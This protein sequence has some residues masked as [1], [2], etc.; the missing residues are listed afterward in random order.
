MFLS[1]GPYDT[2][3]TQQASEIIEYGTAD[4]TRESTPAS[5]FLR[6]VSSLVRS[7][8]RVTGRTLERRQLM[9]VQT[10]VCLRLLVALPSPLTML[11]TKGLYTTVEFME[12]KPRTHN[13]YSSRPIRHHWVELIQKI[14]SG[15]IH[16]YYGGP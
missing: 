3:S 8:S 16:Y 14:L 13:F 2:S 1:F 6:R 10:D 11:G 12:E 15:R 5:L 9:L 4:Y 7:V